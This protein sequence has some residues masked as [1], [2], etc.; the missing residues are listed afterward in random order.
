MPP[1]YLLYDCHLHGTLRPGANADMIQF[2]IAA[3]RQRR[4]NPAA[5]RLRE[6]MEPC[7]PHNVAEPVAQHYYRPC[8][9]RPSRRGQFAEVKP[10]AVV[11]PRYAAKRQRDN[12]AV[13]AHNPLRFSRNYTTAGRKET[14]CF[15]AVLYNTMPDFC[16]F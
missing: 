12:T 5:E 9:Y 7:K 8:V 6:V 10:V 13:H 11:F 3:G 16:H 15:F 1:A 2:L 14:V 4:G